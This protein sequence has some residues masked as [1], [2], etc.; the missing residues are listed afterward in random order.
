MPTLS[1]GPVKAASTGI[2]GALVTVGVT[3]AQHYHYEPDPSLVAAV[4]TLLG[5]AT[6][7]F[8]PHSLRRGSQT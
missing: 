7:Y 4:M 5:A 1:L 3:V 2:A 6:T 8:T